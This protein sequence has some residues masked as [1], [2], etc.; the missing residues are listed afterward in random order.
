MPDIASEHRPIFRGL[1]PTAGSPMTVP[2]ER[3][4]ACL[5]LLERGAERRRQREHIPDLAAVSC[6]RRGDVFAVVGAMNGVS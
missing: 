1:S 5:P 3:V 4:G 2:A 6:Y